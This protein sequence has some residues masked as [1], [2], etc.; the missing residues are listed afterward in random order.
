MPAS[1]FIWYE[2]MT[3][4]LDA[5]VDFYT[6]VVG[7]RP[8]E[9]PGSDMRY[10]VVNAG[11][12]GVAGL[13][14]IPEEAAKM[15]ARP[16]W[17]G[18]IHA[19]DV[20]KATASIKKAGGAVHR[21]PTDIP[22]VGR[23]SVVA[24]PHGASFM[25]MK[26]QGPDQPAV[27]PNTPGHIG[28][29]EL[30]ANDGTSAWDFYSGQFGWTKGDAMDMGKDM[31]LYQLFLAGG[32]AAIGGMM[33]K[34]PDMPMPMWVYYFNVPGID[35]AA[36]RVTDNKGKIIMGPMEV[37]GGSWVLQAIDPQGAVFALLAP[38]R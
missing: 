27:P 18:Y 13:M 34:T 12:R 23:F 20:D 37:P 35:D 25:L 19:A 21:E 31:G 24:D 4:D 26:P 9:F 33:T 2:L 14:A 32:D 22:N 8:E 17:M 30:F 11:D 29:H 28:W 15:G 7:W 3:T 16:A 38:K 5:A 36:R 1:P 10:V 6:K